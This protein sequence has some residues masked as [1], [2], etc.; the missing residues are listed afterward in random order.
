M[1][2]G[3]VWCLRALISDSATHRTPTALPCHR[4]AMK[5]F[6]LFAAAAATA[7]AAPLV[8]ADGAEGHPW[9][10]LTTNA[11]VATPSQWAEY[12]EACGGD[13]QSPIDIS[14]KSCSSAA[15]DSPLT[16]DG[17]CS[18]Y[19]LTQSHE[20]YK[21]SVVGGT[22][23]CMH[24]S[25][26]ST[27]FVPNPRSAALDRLVQRQHGRRGVRPAAVPRAHAVGAH[28]QR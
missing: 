25:D 24:W 16:F 7:L 6:A 27:R 21:G 13:R 9:G 1:L 12:Y 22:S 2:A 26:N 20:A 11:S 8:A 17:E 23:Y 28:A 10:Y 18:D 5:C 3:R 4:D 14:T 19:T 15:S